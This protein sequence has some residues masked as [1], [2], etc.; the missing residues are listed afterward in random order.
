MALP[1]LLGDR[2]APS[3]SLSGPDD[4]FN[5]HLD[6]TRANMVRAHRGGAPLRLVDYRAMT[7]APGPN[8]YVM[9]RAISQTA[10]KSIPGTWAFAIAR[11]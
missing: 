8:D 6:A 9:L 3:A 1:D 2:P 7:E 11:L 10:A 5:E 4:R